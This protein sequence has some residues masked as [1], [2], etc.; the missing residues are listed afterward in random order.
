MRVPDPIDLYWGLTAVE[1]EAY[2]VELNDLYMT[3]TGRR[4]D[5]APCTGLVFKETR[6]PEGVITSQP[7]D[8]VHEPIY[9]E[10]CSDHQSCFV[11]TTIRHRKWNR[12][13]V[14]ISTG[15][16]SLFL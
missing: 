15:C 9:C 5:P 16:L 6:S 3:M 14:A 7:T 11:H 2:M 13:K 12:S 8:C 10:S 4:L 1:L